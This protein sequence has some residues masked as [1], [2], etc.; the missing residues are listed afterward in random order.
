MHMTDAIRRTHFTVDI[1]TREIAREPDDPLVLYRG[2]RWANRL[3]FTF[4]NQGAPVDTQGYTLLLEF[5]RPDQVKL[6]DKARAQAD[7]LACTLPPAVYAE[8]GPLLLYCTLTDDTHVVTSFELRLTVRD[9]LGLDFDMAY[10]LGN[11]LPTYA[12]ILQLILQLELALGLADPD[13]PAQEALYNRLAALEAHMRR[14]AGFATAAQGQAADA[15]L[16][17]AAFAPQN[18]LDKLREADGHGSGL[19]ADTLDGLHAAAFGTAAA[20]Q[21]AQSTATAAQTATGAAQS[22]ANTAQTAADTAH[23]RADSAHALASGKLRLAVQ[24]TPPAADATVL[25][26]IP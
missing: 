14:T 22:A 24:A 1:H 17:A 23:T 9:K 10:D 13:N 7:G 20:V 12:E 25:W 11:T 16:P 21:A 18:V 5:V 15:A 2:D 19:D 26:V 4:T 3:C 6:V 8:T